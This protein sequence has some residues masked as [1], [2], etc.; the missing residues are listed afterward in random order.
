MAGRQRVAYGGRR[1]RTWSTLSDKVNGGAA[2]AR[3]A[4]ELARLQTS[5]RP[6]QLLPLLLLFHLCF[7]P[8][9]PAATPKAVV[10]LKIGIA[11]RWS[12]QKG[13]LQQNDS[14]RRISRSTHC[15]S[16]AALARLLLFLLHLPSSLDDHRRRGDAL[17]GASFQTDAGR[18]E[19]ECVRHFYLIQLRG[20]PPGSPKH[21]GTQPPSPPPYFLLTSFSQPFRA[22]NASNDSPACIPHKGARSPG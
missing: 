2:A 12:R 8:K 16:L 1:A 9:P 13:V 17:A 5:S 22:H 15:T 3:D 10:A 14:L 4:W 7:S 11:R 20:H 19:Q 18:L 21:T 6:L